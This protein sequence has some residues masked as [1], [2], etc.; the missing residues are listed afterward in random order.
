MKD[1]FNTMR[2]FKTGLTAWVA[3]FRDKRDR[4][5]KLALTL[6]RLTD[7]RSLRESLGM[8][9][10]LKNDLKYQRFVY[11]KEVAGLK[12]VEQVTPKAYPTE[13]SQN[14]KVI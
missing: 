2:V 11:F 12:K 14:F 13:G 8:V 4:E 10:E 1:R 7:K 9:K 6:L 5:A 3:A